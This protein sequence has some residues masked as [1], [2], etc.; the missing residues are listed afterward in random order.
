MNI[1]RLLRKNFWAVP[2]CSAALIALLA[3]RAS[4]YGVAFALAAGTGAVPAPMLTPAN[5]TPP[6]A[7]L[8]S[9]NAVLARNPFDHVTG[10]LQSSASANASDAMASEPNRDP[11]SAPHCA[12]TQLRAISA[13]ADPAWSFAAFVTADNTGKSLM[14]RSGQRVGEDEVLHIGADRVW[15][16]QS[17]NVCQVEL[18]ADAHPNRAGAS[19]AVTPELSN[20][21]ASA[22]GLDPTIAKGIV[23]LSATEFNIDRATLDRI[24]ENQAT[25]MSQVRIVPMQAPGQPSGIKLLGIKPESVLAK[26]GMLNGDL[27]QAINGFDVTSPERALEAYTRLTTTPRLTVQINRR[28]RTVNLD[29]HV[30]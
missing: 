10:S 6:V 1:N 18:H 14:R 8:R 17:G 21:A 2:V 3:A 13:S 7:R 30:Q 28:G 5:S 29:Y 16:R 4:S 15:L 25:L 27:L 26:V 11:Q 23:Q 20:A 12:S 24:L 9:A 22:Q 19:P